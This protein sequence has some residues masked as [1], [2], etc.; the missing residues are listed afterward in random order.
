MV[1][2]GVGSGGGESGVGVREG[3]VMEKCDGE[4]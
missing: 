1:E 4:M 3:N 2:I